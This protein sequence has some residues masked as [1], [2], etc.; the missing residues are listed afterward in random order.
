VYCWTNQY[1][2]K[3]ADKNGV[4]YNIPTHK[5][6]VMDQAQEDVQFLEIKSQFRIQAVASMLGVSISTVKNDERDSGIEVER[7]G[8]GGPDVRLFSVQNIFDL[9]NF[10]RQTGR[11]KKL[12]KPI[13]ATVY[14]LKGG[15]GKSTTTVELATQFQFAGL[16][17]LVI[18][19][20][21][22]ASATIMMGYDPEL[23]FEMAEHCGIPQDQV[24]NFTFGNLF[25]LPPLY[26][27]RTLGYP[28]ATYAKL[29][30]VLKKPF[31]ENGPHLIPADVSLANLD[32][33]LVN[34]SNRDYKIM[35]LLA[36][37]MDGSNQDVDMSMYDVILMDCP[38]A[39]SS[40]SKGALLASDFCIS[41][42]R[43]EKLSTKG[44]S[45]LSAEMQGLYDDFNRAPE[46]AVVP[47]CYNE[48]LTR[49]GNTMNVLHRY[50]AENVTNTTI[51]NS[52][53]LPK[54][55]DSQCPLSI[56][57]PSSAVIAQDM[58]N[59]SNELIEKFNKKGA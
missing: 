25:N 14:L 45:R 19:L 56:M 11:T 35:N 12:L 30:D 23:E 10:R 48:K 59:L 2:A 21:P 33:A 15:V 43:L 42:V 31:G 13:I 24:V 58:R 26:D 54:N 3:N 17:C 34:A 4:N 49:V 50:F 41:P 16:K 47:T 5:E 9:A 20:D 38:P 36:S 29:Q 52:E 18:D 40:S 6:P 51:R 7:S 8:G 46:L 32:I 39:A 27:K 1:N 22:Q 37:A 57:K 55:L 44:L 53:D 28:N